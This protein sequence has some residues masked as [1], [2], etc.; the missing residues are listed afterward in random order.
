MLYGT[1]IG[2]ILSNRRCGCSRFGSRQHE[3]AKITVETVDC[4]VLLLG[5]DGSHGL[6]LSFVSHIFLLDKIWNPS[7]EKQVVARAY[8]MGSTASVEI[9]TLI[10][11]DTIEDLMLSLEQDEQQPTDDSNTVQTLKGLADQTLSKQETPGQVQQPFQVAEMR[12]LHYLLRRIRL[13]RDDPEKKHE[14]NERGSNREGSSK[15][16]RIRFNV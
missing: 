11:K 10:M 13:V 15:R 4:F 8:R 3:A 9:E 14:R 16:K 7:L 1:R 12:K 6:D 5:V 2:V